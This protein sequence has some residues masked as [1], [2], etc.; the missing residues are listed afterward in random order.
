[1]IFGK[2]VK[3][4]SRFFSAYLG[5]KRKYGEK[6]AEI[7]SQHKGK[8]CYDIFGGSGSLTCQLSPFFDKL[9]YNEKNIFVARFIEIA[10]DK[11]SNDLFDEWWEN[12]VMAWEISG[13]E[14]YFGVR[15]RF[16]NKCDS[17][18]V[19][20]I[21]YF[22]LNHTC[23]SALVRWNKNKV[24]D[25]PWYFNQAY[26]GK[27]INSEKT[28][29]ILLDGLKCVQDKDFETHCSDYEDLSTEDGALLL[30]DPPYD[31]TYSDY[32]P[33]SWDSDRF[34]AWLKEKS[35]TNPVCLFGST[36]E[37]DFSD[38]KNLKPF[39]DA[40]WKVLVLSEKAFNGVSPHGE[41]HEN[42]QD[43]TKQKDVMLYNF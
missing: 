42:A 26:C 34:V 9:I 3:S 36:K 20:C 38:T 28:K 22:W 13:K 32:L 23:T 29:Q 19:Q 11:F 40:G 33:E 31:N 37:D 17:F 4:N 15:E 39:F 21:Q 12:E 1:M 30:I 6:I 18:E 41:N 2:Q 8:T 43:R 10:Y 35:K 5:T 24:P 7:T 16:N 14:L 25:N 27:V